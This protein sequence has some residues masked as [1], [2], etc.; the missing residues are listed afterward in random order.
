VFASI[1][2]DDDGVLTQ[3]ELLDYLLEQGCEPEQA[4][5]YTSRLPPFREFSTAA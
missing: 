2:A 3:D 5:F 1:D 4:G